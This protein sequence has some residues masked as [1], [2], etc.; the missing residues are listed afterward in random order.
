[1]ELDFVIVQGDIVKILQDKGLGLGQP[2]E[3][4]GK[5]EPQRFTGRDQGRHRGL[6]QIEM[7]VDHLETGLAELF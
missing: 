2:G 3:N 7:Q 1:M 5:E 6:G 4:P